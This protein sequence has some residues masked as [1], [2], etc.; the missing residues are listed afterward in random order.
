MFLVDTHLLLWAAYSPRRLSAAAAK[1][2]R[3]KEALAF[4]FVS[5]WEVGIKISL[6][7][8]N[9]SIDPTEL[10][11]GLLAQGYGALAMTPAHCTRLST[12]P[13][14]HRDPFDRM[15]VAQAVEDGL[16]LLT[17]DKTLASYGKSVRVV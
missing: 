2:L 7:R 10:H 15:L 17:A 1:V 16:T 9:L 8:S 4:S 6:P 11:R 14:L 3:S 12:L 13:W 5:L